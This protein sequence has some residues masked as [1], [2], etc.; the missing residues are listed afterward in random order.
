MTTPLPVMGQGLESPGSLLPGDNAEET[1][2]ASGEQADAAS[3]VSACTCTQC[4][5]P[6]S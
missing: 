3:E 6:L 4:I 5:C 1:L 2:V